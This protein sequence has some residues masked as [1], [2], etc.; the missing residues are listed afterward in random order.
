MELVEATRKRLATE[1]KA[2]IVKEKERLQARNTLSDGKLEDAKEEAAREHQVMIR[3]KKRIVEKTIRETMREQR[4]RFDEEQEL[5]KGDLKTQLTE[6]YDKKEKKLDNESKQLKQ[7]YEEKRANYVEDTK[8][9]FDQE[10]S[11][12]QRQ[13]DKE[14]RDEQAAFENEEQEA[15]EGQTAILKQIEE[16][17]EKV[18]KLTQRHK[19]LDKQLRREQT[20]VEDFRVDKKIKLQEFNDQKLARQS[21]AQ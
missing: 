21:N 15:T 11:A 16:A 14:W 19:D 18:K 13:M 7:E 6:K 1:T 5:A 20:E 17:K 4:E 2:R 9:S 3:D 10:K 12:I 8:I